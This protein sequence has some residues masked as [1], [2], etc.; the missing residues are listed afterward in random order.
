LRITNKT[1]ADLGQGYTKEQVVEECDKFFNEDGLTPVHR[2]I[3]AHNAPFDMRFCHALW[4]KVG[5]EFPAALWVDS[6]QIVRA[7]AKKIGLVKPKVNLDAS[8]N[9]LGIK[10]FAGAHSAQS[11]TRNT[12]LLWKALTETHNM[13]PLPFIKTLPHV[14]NPV[15]DSE[16][17]GL[18]PA[19]LDL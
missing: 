13:D 6:M 14:L 8:C 1:L 19:L 11:D 5:K 2:C 18:D 16:D 9:M 17:C 12:Y 15:D 4:A 3:I 10:K 7:Y